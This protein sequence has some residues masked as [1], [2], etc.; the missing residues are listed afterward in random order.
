MEY[1]YLRKTATELKINHIYAKK[2][3]IKDGYL[4]NDGHPTE[5]GKSVGIIWVGEEECRK[6]IWF[7]HGKQ[8]NMTMTVHAE[9]PKSFLEPY[10]IKNKEAIAIESKKAYEVPEQGIEVP[11]Y[12]NPNDI[13]FHSDFVVLC[14]SPIKKFKEKDVVDIAEIT[15][16]DSQGNE[17]YHSLFKPILP[18]NI[19][20]YKNTGLIDSMLIN[21][22]SIE[23]E[24]ETLKQLFNTYKSRKIVCADAD[25][26]D[27]LLS[28]F[29]LH[30]IDV[31]SN[32]FANLDTYYVIPHAMNQYSVRY[33]TIRWACK[34][35][36]IKYDVPS[37][38]SYDCHALL[39]CLTKLKK[40]TT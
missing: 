33:K 23:D 40:E 30:S 29:K 36:N 14:V 25:V 11:E 20:V 37:R 6:R 27:M 15:L 13:R 10:L 4:D 5:K 7:V 35:M 12:K 2:F 8:T 22:K 31:P 3:L 1:I 18:I 17:I 39:H 19:A 9:Y 26:F 38:T 28:A 34:A 16:M 24:F 32:V 21:Q